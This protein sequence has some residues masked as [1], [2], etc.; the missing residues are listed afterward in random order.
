V[1]AWR[2]LPAADGGWR[3]L[4]DLAGLFPRRYVMIACDVHR[5]GTVGLMAISGMPF[6]A[7]CALLLFTVPAGSPG[8]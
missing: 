4:S 8:G 2:S 7:S 5:I 1:F 6:V 3:V